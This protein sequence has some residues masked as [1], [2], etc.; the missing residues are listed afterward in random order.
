MVNPSHVRV[1]TIHNGDSK[2]PWWR[3]RDAEGVLRAYVQESHASAACSVAE[4][5]SVDGPRPFKADP[6]D[7]KR[8]VA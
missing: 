2:L 6:L 7:P 1:R 3:V 4:G 8:G 5:W